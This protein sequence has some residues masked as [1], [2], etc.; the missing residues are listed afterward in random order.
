M[1]GQA[2]GGIFLAPISEVFGR[3]TIYIIGAVV[4][5]LA[6]V[7]TGVPH[8]LAAATI[9]RFI[10]GVAAA[11]PATVAFGN[12]HDLYDA[13]TRVWVVYFYTLFGMAGLALGPI[14]SSYVTAL[15]GW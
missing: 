14:Y 8:S 2:L 15:L 6:S 13:N 12:F 4:F 3:R 11:I 10:Q 9:G 7:I 5:G 1:I